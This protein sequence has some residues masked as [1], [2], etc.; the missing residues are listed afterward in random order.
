ML[1]HAIHA[2]L[3]CPWLSQY[4]FVLL[5]PPFW[6]HQPIRFSLKV[7][8]LRQCFFF[9]ENTVF[10]TADSKYMTRVSRPNTYLTCFVIFKN[11]FWFEWCYIYHC[12]VFFIY[13]V[14]TPKYSQGLSKFWCWSKN[15]KIWK[16]N[17]LP[18]FFY[19]LPSAG[20]IFSK[21][22]SITYMQSCY[23]WNKIEL[24]PCFCI[25]SITE[26]TEGMSS[27]AKFMIL[28]LRISNRSA[29]FFHLK[30]KTLLLFP[31]IYVALSISYI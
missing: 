5:L 22:I 15:N 7:N 21:C 10:G 23:R 16:I 1:D 28:I 12:L 6:L 29:L 30:L 2:G 18:C 8:S 14:H 24:L 31:R 4:Y 27:I 11:L 17:T 9:H 26:A 13:R 19:Y 3:C 25:T 20:L